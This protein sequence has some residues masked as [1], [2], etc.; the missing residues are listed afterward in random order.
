MSRKGMSVRPEDLPQ[1]GHPRGEV[2]PRARP[3]RDQIVLGVDQRT[4]TDEAHL[5]TEHVPELRKLVETASPQE[6]PDAGNAR[7]AVELQPVR[8]VAERAELLGPGLG[9]DDHGPE[10]DHRE[11]FT[12]PADPPLAKQHGPG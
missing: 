2:E 8:V 9:V 6:A 5:A 7:V 11:R 10:L 3:A 12:A 1:A 4:G